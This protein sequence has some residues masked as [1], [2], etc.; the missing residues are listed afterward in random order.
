MLLKDAV[1]VFYATSLKILH[2]QNVSK[3]HYRIVPFYGRRGRNCFFFSF[4]I[5][6][7]TADS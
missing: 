2:T 4:D 5:V 6:P 1:S 7:L 3:D